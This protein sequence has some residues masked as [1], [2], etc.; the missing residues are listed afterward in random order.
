MPD[1]ARTLIQGA[2]EQIKIY[3]PGQPLAA[4]DAAR[5]LSVMNQFL[6]E[7]SNQSLA[8]FANLEQS[9]TLVPGQYQYTIGPGGNINGP[10]P[11]LLNTKPGSA[12]LVDANQNRYPMNIIEQDQW[13]QIGLLNQTSQLPD[14]IFYDP[15]YPLGIINIFPTPSIA[16]QV[17]FDSR[18]QLADMPTLDTAFNL[19]PGYSSMIQNNMAIRLWPFFKQGDP[20]VYLMKLAGDSLGSVKRANIRY[21]ASTVDSSIVSRAQAGY[22]I[23]NDGFNRADR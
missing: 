7:L 12:Y 3:A 15:Q 17:F 23:Y 10:R 13:N 14:T 20:G 1:T 11:L 4:A 5:G 2:L 16:Y 22:N 6:D 9:F 21:S 18:L 8:V 19:P